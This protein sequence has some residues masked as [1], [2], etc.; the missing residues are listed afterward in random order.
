MFKER[1]VFLESNSNLPNILAIGV[2]QEFHLKSNLFNEIDK[3]ILVNKGS[4]L[5]SCLSYD[6]KNRLENVKSE[7]PDRIEFP[8]ILLWKAKL[9]V[10]IKDQNYITL[11]GKLNLEYEEILKQFLSK[12]SEIKLPKI[13]FK[14][15]ISKATYIDSVEKIK[16]QIQLGNVYELNFCQEFYAENIPE[17][18]EI[19]LFNQLN[20]LTKAPFSAYIN[21]EN[22]Q[23]FCS[24][25]ERFLQKIG[26]KLISQPIKGTSKRGENQVEDELLKTRLQKDPKERAEN[27]MITDLV[28]ND[29]SRIAKKSSV[30]VDELCEIYS[31][32]TV[33]QMISTISCDL[34]EDT[35]FSTILKACFPMGSMTGAPKIS[36]MNLIEQFESFKRGLYSGSIAYFKPNG[37]FDFNVVIRTIIHNKAEKLI[38]AAVGGAITIQSDPEKEFE[39]CQ[40]KIQ[41][42]LQLFQHD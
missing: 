24:S 42:L 12:R 18:D 25:P 33:H 3:F 38:S 30:S 28:R 15:Q 14:S 17:F 22:H 31:F 27:I 36:S 29:F 35:S 4:Y 11:D 26:N 34:K 23:V 6:L 2:E 10:E 9:V 41:K 19:A 39:E 20:Q 8:E 21:L 37:D 16:E 1:I 40:V 5:F 7:N 13:D 32:G